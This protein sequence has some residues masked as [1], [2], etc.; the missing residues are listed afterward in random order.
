[1]MMSLGLPACSILENLE[2]AVAFYILFRRFVHQMYTAR[3][4]MQQSL[5]Y[6]DSRTHELLKSPPSSRYAAA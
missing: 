2:K 6:E 3:D 5:A 1:M 4:R